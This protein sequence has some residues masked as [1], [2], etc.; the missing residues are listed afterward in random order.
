MKNKKINYETHGTHEMYEDRILFACPQC[1]AQ[2]CRRV[3]T[4]KQN[5]HEL[6][7]AAGQLYF[8]SLGRGIR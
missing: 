4:K 5:M 2:R 6:G 8:L 7:P 1:Y 3:I